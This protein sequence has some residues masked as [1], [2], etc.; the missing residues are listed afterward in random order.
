MAAMPFLFLVRQGFHL[1]GDYIDGFIP[2]GG[3]EGTIFLHQGSVDPLPLLFHW[4]KT[5]QFAGQACTNS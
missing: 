1:A 5:S 4:D 3:F 2:G